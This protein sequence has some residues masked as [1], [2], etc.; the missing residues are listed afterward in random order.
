LLLYYN[1]WNQNRINSF[2][3]TNKHGKKINTF[4]TKIIQAHNSKKK[5]HKQGLLNISFFGCQRKNKHEILL[6]KIDVM[7]LFQRD[8]PF[9]K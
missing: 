9:Q 4:T 8:L 6:A 2:S 5:N 1:G 7:H 3:T